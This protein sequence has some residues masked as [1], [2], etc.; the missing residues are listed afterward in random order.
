MCRAT[1]GSSSCLNTSNSKDT[2][3]DNRITS[4]RLSMVADTINEGDDDSK[5]S[6]YLDNGDEMLSYRENDN[7]YIEYDGLDDDIAGENY[8]DTDGSDRFFEVDGNHIDGGYDE[9]NDLDQVLQGQWGE[10][11]Y[12]GGGLSSDQG[13]TKGSAR[14]ESSADMDTENW[15][16]ST[17]RSDVTIQYPEVSPLCG[18]KTVQR[19]TGECESPIKGHPKSQTN[20]PTL[21]L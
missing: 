7:N 10:E 4:L 11:E 16:G 21:L 18:G 6:G 5:C 3:V 17:I 9:E 14:A 15:L 19:T 20:N 8:H 13:N 2:S 1:I 12:S